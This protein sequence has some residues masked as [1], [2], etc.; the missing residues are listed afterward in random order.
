MTYEEAT[1]RKIERYRRENRLCAGIAP[2]RYT[3]L[4]HCL[5]PATLDYDGQRYCNLHYP[6][7]VAAQKEKTRQ[8]KI[9]YHRKK[10]AELETS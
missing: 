9:A 10:L 1:Q 6:P 5:R 7:R 8:V 3:K 2:Q 4:H